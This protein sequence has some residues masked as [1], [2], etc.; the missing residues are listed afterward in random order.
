MA[1][2][3]AT[4]CALFVL[5]VLFLPSIRIIGPTQV[6]LIRKRFGSKLSSENPIAFSGEAGYQSELLMPGWRFKFWIIYSIE[7]FPWAQIPAGEIGVVISQVGKP[8]RVGAKSAV[9]KKEFGIFEDLKAFVDNGGQKGVQRPVLPPGTLAPYHPVGFLVITADKV[10]GKPISPDLAETANRRG[11]LK[12]DDFGLH[13]SDL[14]VKIIKP[15]KAGDIDPKTLD[16]IG[17]RKVREESIIDTVGIV[18]TFEGDPLP[19]G[20]IASRLG[21]FDDIA[22]LEKNNAVDSELI[23]AIVGTKNDKHNNY[24]DFQEFLDAGGKIGLQHDPLLY[25]AFNLNPFLV[26]VEIVP[27]LVVEQGEVAV[28]KSYVGQVSE[29]T[30]G[31]TFRYGSLVKPGHKGIWEE[32]LRTGKYTINPRLYQ[33]EIVPTAIVTLNWAT[34]VSEAHKLDERLSQIIAKSREGFVFNIDLQV[35]IHISDIK[36]SRVISMVGTI[37]NLVNE[38]LQAAVGNHFRDK[39]QSMPAVDF[40]Q[41]R[42]RVQEEAFDYIKQK[43][44]EYDVETLGVYI[45]D[46]IFPATLVD[47]LTKREIANQEIATY[48]KQEEAQKQRVEM[49]QQTGVADM[50]KDLAKSRIGV[51]I[52]QKNAEARKAEADGEAEY[53]RK[54][55]EAEGAKERAIGEG[56]A[57]GYL[58]QIDALGREGTALVNVIQA[59]A[60]NNVPIVPQISSGA[61]LGLSNIIGILTAKMKDEYDKKDKR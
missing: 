55:G 22:E 48:R 37:Q 6:G 43:L 2:L 23:D 20:D 49:E 36:A 30:S 40:I 28:I 41:T 58:K 5:A 24:Q 12:C 16:L 35:L 17:A 8:I 39:L 7:K 56:K 38:V 13:Q 47:V 26:S 4:L 32:P 44:T 33:A 14:Q 29:D 42:Q 46:V 19:S 15:T 50:Q 45:Q 10:Y 59:L 9:Y 27:M 61:D 11:G 25:G 34:D 1:G 53:I 54:T 51:E 18:T 21:G 31:E 60:Q 52:K 57:A 3:I